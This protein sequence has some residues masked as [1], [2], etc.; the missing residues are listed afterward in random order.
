MSPLNFV[1]SGYE[2]IDTERGTYEV[3]PEWWRE[4]VT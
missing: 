4:P 2:Q 1:L 3:R